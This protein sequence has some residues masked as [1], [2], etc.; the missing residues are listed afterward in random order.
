M[1]FETLSWDIA[2]GIVKIIPTDFKRKMKFLED[3]L[4]QNQGP[5]SQEDTSSIRSSRSSTS[6]RHVVIR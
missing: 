2:K 6:T 1:E 4:Y 5:C 3:Q